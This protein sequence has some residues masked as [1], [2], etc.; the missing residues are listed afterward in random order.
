PH[1]KLDGQFFTEIHFDAYN[2]H[3]WYDYSES[4]NN[5]RRTVKDKLKV[6]HS[7]IYSYFEVNNLKELAPHFHT[8][9]IVYN[10]CYKRNFT[11]KEL[12]SIWLHYG[13]RKE[14]IPAGNKFIDLPRIQIILH[15]NDIGIWLV[16]GKNQ[17][18]IS[19]R[20]NLKKKL[21]DDKIWRDDLYKDFVFLGS[22]YEL[23]VS[24][25]SESVSEVSSANHLAELFQKDDPNNYL[26][27][28]RVYH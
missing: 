25:S 22:S 5:K 4:A 24:N 13:Y 19:L 14:D 17:G 20:K 1:H 3:L 26:I 16:I 8:K 18:S 28:R 12:R 9:S 11:S 23:C 15:N 10:H 2:S 6:L 27:V 21:N 7:L